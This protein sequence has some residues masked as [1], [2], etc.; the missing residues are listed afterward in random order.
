MSAP[1]THIPSRTISPIATAD[2]CVI[3]EAQAT[4]EVLGLTNVSLSV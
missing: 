3:L 2:H 4:S 1:V